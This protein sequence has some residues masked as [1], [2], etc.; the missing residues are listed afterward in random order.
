MA[1]ENGFT[2]SFNSPVDDNANQNIAKVT[3]ASPSPTPITPSNGFGAGGTVVDDSHENTSVV[4]NT[5]VNAHTD[6][7]KKPEE[8]KPIPTPQ[9]KPEPQPQPEPQPK[10]KPEPEPN[11]EPK[12]KDPPKPEGPPVITPVAEPKVKNTDAPTAAGIGIVSSAANAAVVDSMKNKNNETRVSTG[13]SL[14]GGYAGGN[15]TNARVIGGVGTLVYGNNKLAGYVSTGVSQENVNGTNVGNVATEVGVTKKLDK[16][17]LN[18]HVNTSHVFGSQKENLKDGAAVSSYG[19]G[20]RVGYDVKEKT[21]IFAGYDANRN[22]DK[23][24]QHFNSQNIKIGLSTQVSETSKHDIRAYVTGQA[25]LDK[26]SSSGGFVGVSMKFDNKATTGHVPVIPLKTPTPAPTPKEEPALNFKLSSA[27]L[28]DHDKY[29][30]KDSAKPQ[31]DEFAKKLL[32]PKLLANG[33]S[34]QDLLKENKQTIQLLSNTDAT[35]SKRYNETLSM[36]RGFAVRNYL[37][38]KGVDPKILDVIANGETKAQYDDK[39]IAQMR[40]SGMKDAA[41]KEKIADDRNVTISIPGQYTL[42]KGQSLP[43]NAVVIDG[44]NP[45]VGPSGSEELLAKSNEPAKSTVSDTLD[46][47]RKDGHSAVQNVKEQLEQGK[48]TVQNMIANGLETVANKVKS[49]TAMP[50]HEQSHAHVQT[51]DKR[52]QSEMRI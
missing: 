28:F 46:K 4:N 2:G 22:T 36:N 1:N 14:G 13:F 41:I 45:K 3:P 51:Q 44:K 20:F 25:G 34:M 52:L 39:A 10:P 17:S 26:N 9:P 37:A 23:N 32:D 38:E 6:V 5:N 27:E 40:K 33:K 19:A 24:G 31:L 18:A 48:V 30:I 29:V 47:I 49:D 12:P 43:K 15:G 8:P 35:G 21:N 11:P 42:A 50:T 16:A 7:F